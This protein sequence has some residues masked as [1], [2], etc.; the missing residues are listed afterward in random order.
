MSLRARTAFAALAALACMG[1]RAAEASK[2]ALSYG[3][4]GSYGACGLT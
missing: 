4:G 3:A 1:P 2:N